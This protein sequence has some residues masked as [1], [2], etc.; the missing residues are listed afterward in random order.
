MPAPPDLLRPR[1]TPAGR[2]FFGL[3][4]VLA[5]AVAALLSAD[6]APEARAAVVRLW[7]LFAAGCLA[8]AAPHVLL[9]DPQLD[10]L[11]HVNPPP[12][13]LLWRGLWRWSPVVALVGL[14]VLVLAFAGEGVLLRSAFVPRVVAALDAALLVLGIGLYS[15]AVYG[16]LGAVSQAWQEGRAGQ[17]Y[18]RMGEH[19]TTARADI[20]LGLVPAVT[21]T[22]RVFIVAALA[23]G[24]GATLDRN[25]LYA[26][27]WLPGAAVLLLGGLRLRRLA[28]AFDRHFYQTNGFYDEL[29]RRAGGIR[30]EA[31]EPLPY[32]AVYWVPARLKPHAWMLLRQL[33]R[34]LPLGRLV[35]VGHVVFW[36]L[37]LRAASPAFVGAYL[38]L[39][40][41]AKNAAVFL[42]ATD[43]LLP[44]PVAAV[45]ASAGAWAL[46]RFFVN[47]RW[48]L[49]WALSLALVA[50]LSEALSGGAVAA[51]TALDAVLA[52]GAAAAATLTREVRHRRAFA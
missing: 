17:W 50:A 11:P 52:V 35:M 27:A 1:P 31:R 6:V 20:P 37:V 32:A 48:T 15:F 22:G 49:P 43:R 19:S 36:L 33:D 14:P 30:A 41:A 44:L 25:G 42:T 16:S 23:W 28:A 13:A 24:L 21:A 26:W 2:L 7:A 39:F 9:P 38:L 51:W 40:S 47:L 10:V 3:L 34:R 12:R 18:R 46:G 5:L 45:Q 8:A 4:L 29:F